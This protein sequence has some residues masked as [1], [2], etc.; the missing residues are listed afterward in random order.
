M[1]IKC[2]IKGSTR[3][4][5]GDDAMLLKLKADGIT[6]KANCKAKLPY[7]IIFEETENNL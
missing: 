7:P 6:G 2:D 4:I 3:L 1:Y 5:S